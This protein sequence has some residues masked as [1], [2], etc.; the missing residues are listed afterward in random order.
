MDK[1]DKESRSRLMAKVKS[2]NTGLEKAVRSLLHS[3]GFRFRLHRRGLPG[4]PD[5]ILPKYRT[6]ILAHGCFWH[7][8][9]GCKLAATPASNTDFWREK[10]A[11]NVERDARQIAA[12]E[13]AGWKVMVVWECEL[14]ET[15]RLAARLIEELRGV[16]AG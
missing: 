10:F 11:K 6:V 15:P 13:Q 3:L 16:G 12:L 4:T 9:P 7:R 1:L 5:V 2:K 14:K 8:H